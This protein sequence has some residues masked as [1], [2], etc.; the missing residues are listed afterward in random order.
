M[1]LHASRLKPHCPWARL[2][3]VFPNKNE[4]Q[5]VTLAPEC[6]FAWDGAAASIFLGAIPLAIVLTVA[7]LFLYRWAVGRAM[8]AAS[9]EAAPMRE[10]G[11]P[12]APGHPLQLV[13]LAQSAPLPAAAAALDTS[14]Q[15]VRRLSTA[16]VLAGAVHATLATAILFW[17]SDIDFRVFR[18][19]SVWCVFVWPVVVGL[20]MTAAVT[21]RMQALLVGGYFAGL[22]ALEIIT[23]TFGMRYQPAFGELFL[24]WAITMGPQ[25]LVVVL[26]ANRAWRSV[27]LTALFVSIVLVGAYLLG[28]QLVGCAVL[29]TK[30]MTLF[31]LRNY[32]LLAIV[33]AAGALAWLLLRRSARRYQAKRASDQ[34]FLLDSWWLLVTTLEILFQM[35]HSGL[36]SFW[37]LLAFAAYRLTLGLS[38]RG[39]GLAV[40]PGKPRAMLL[41]RVFGHATRVR[42]LAD[43]VGQTWRHTGPINMIGGTDLAGAL[44]E[45]DELMSF[46]SGKLRQGFVAS[47]TDLAQR[48]ASLD[49]QA[50]PDGRY[51]INEFFCHDNTWRATVHAL[52]QRSAVVL[53]DL[54][55]FGKENRG[56]EFELALLLGEVPLARVVLLVDGSTRMDELK[57]ILLAAWDKLPAS[58]PNRELAQPV[59]QFFQVEN[60]GKALRPLLARLFAAA[61]NI[62]TGG[63]IH[64]I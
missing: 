34:M 35:G 5:P 54:R 32:L 58:S 9:R 42:T 24:L 49:E 4:R 23:E 27:G 11:L 20:T 45:P 26:L 38:L 47:G 2:E 60:G 40:A 22:L 15:A 14:L 48:L 1:R 56:C 7:T 46:W 33:L 3:F 31:A 13:T 61:Q 62:P 52:A 16:Y 30:N 64:Y 12:V 43:Q 28:F 37:F 36:A 44:L 50:D 25:T 19:L 41:L 29:T 18:F 53:M 8:R 17:L 10:P 59:L 63:D 21:R 57:T 51:R 55:G 6:S 39:F